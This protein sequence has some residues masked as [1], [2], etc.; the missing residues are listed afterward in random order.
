M[1]RRAA[2]AALALGLV[3]SLLGCGID[4]AEPETEEPAASD[5]ST[6]ASPESSDLPEFDDSAEGTPGAW[7]RLTDEVSGA[8][9][10]FPEAVAPVGPTGFVGADGAD[11]VTWY[12]EVT[13]EDF[14][15]R[16]ELVAPTGGG[17]MILP[18]RAALRFST[19]S[20]R[21]AGGRDL[22]V[23]IGEPRRR[24]GVSEVPYTVVWTLAGERQFTRLG[25]FNSRG[26]SAVVLV[27]LSGEDRPYA[28]QSSASVYDLVTDGI[29]VPTR[30]PKDLAPVESA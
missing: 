29:E 20:I 28:R 10:V 15:T 19:A 5:R 21:D 18:P 27:T 24:G 8:T 22:D 3:G 16:L 9:F 26:M 2:R 17:P 25:I 6:S 13:D 23:R 30:A 11:F 4:R 14:V 1:R 7:G 12:Y